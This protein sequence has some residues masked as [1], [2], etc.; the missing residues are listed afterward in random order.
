MSDGVAVGLLLDGEGD[1]KAQL[2]YLGGDGLD[3]HAVDAVLDEV[4][5]APEVGAAV[6]LE[7]VADFLEFGVALPLV[8]GVES[9]S[10]AFGG[11]FPLQSSP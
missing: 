1:E 8:G 7:G 3:V 6:A 4:E 10:G 2:G 11:D 5:L 9:G